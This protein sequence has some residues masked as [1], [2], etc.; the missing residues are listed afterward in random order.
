MVLNGYGCTESGA[1][2]STS[3]ATQRKIGTVGTPI[4][5]LELEIRDD[6]DRPLPAGQIGEV[7]CKSPGVMQGYWNAPDVTASTLR[8][9]WLHTGDVGRLDDGYLYIVDRIKDLIIRGGYNIYPRD[10][11]DAMVTHPDVV[12]AAVVGRPDPT[13][14]EEAVAFVQLRPGATVTEADLVAYGK[15]RLSAVKY[16]R[17]V[18][19]IDEVP[20]TSVFKTDRKKLRALLA[21]GA[22]GTATPAS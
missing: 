4:P 14:G 1:V 8:G 5:Y 2:I 19:I 7:C 22:A 17:E 10:L 18:R 12:A 13:Y 3:T 16:P 9:G 20:L 11:E 6:E 21:D 15:E